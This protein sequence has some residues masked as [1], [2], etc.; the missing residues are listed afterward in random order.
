MTSSWPRQPPPAPA[1]APP[2]TTNTAQHHGHF[3]PQNVSAPVYQQQNMQFTSTGIFPGT[4]QEAA[5]YT[6]QPGMGLFEP[7][8]GWYPEAEYGMG[9]GGEMRYYSD[10]KGGSL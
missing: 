9:A 10:G 1:S 8:L 4:A 2:F 6:A 7:E 3:Q 5:A